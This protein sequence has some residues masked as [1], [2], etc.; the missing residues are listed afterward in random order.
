MPARIKRRKVRRQRRSFPRLITA[1]FF[2][3]FLVLVFYLFFK[4]HVWDKSQRLTLATLKESGDV[5]V[6][7]FDPQNS[8]IT[9]FLIPGNTEVNV[10]KQLGQWK[11]K[12][13][14]K[15]GENEGLGGKLLSE[16]ITKS[17]KAPVEAW[18]SQGAM[19]LTSSLPSQVMKAVL[20]GYETNL[21]LRDRVNLGIFSLK[22]KNSSKI[23]IDMRETGYLQPMLLADGEEGF[24]VKSVIPAKIAAI[25]AD[26]QISKEGI[27]VRIINKTKDPEIANHIGQIIEMMGAKVVAINQEEIDETDCMVISRK[28]F[29]ASK[30]AKI[31]SCELEEKDG[32]NP[33][34]DFVFGSKFQTRF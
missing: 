8:T 9:S 34:L 30:I 3:V 25:F 12:S 28:T 16:T 23:F 14:W 33:N 13:V 26:S 21:S 15:L 1:I 2:I 29:T 10:S 17:F 32:E 18:A 20:G 27:L 24:K 22:V 7:F 4:P 19:G 5:V 11:L 31:F 6:S